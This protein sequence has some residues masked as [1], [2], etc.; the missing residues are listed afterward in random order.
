MDTESDVSTTVSNWSR[1]RSIGDA[2]N[3]GT[4]L[5]S[6]MAAYPDVNFRYVLY[7]QNPAGAGE[8]D[9]N[10]DYTWPMQEAGRADAQAALEQAYVYQDTWK[11]WRDDELLNE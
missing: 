8:I 11:M 4:S 6:F 10:G 5:D 7:E 3:S 9:F 2:Y 1:A